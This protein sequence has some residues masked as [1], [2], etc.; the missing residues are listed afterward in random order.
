M[1]QKQY[2]LQNIIAYLTWN[3]TLNTN[4][5]KFPQRLTSIQYVKK[6]KNIIDIKLKK[7]LSP[8]VKGDYPNMD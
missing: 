1:N 4:S 5:G 8:M 6:I 3:M 7:Y 2:E